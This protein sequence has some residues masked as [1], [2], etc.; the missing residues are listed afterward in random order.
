MIEN[1]LERARAVQE[2]TGPSLDALLTDAA[3]DKALADATRY[4]KGRYEVGLPH[5]TS[6]IQQIGISQGESV[7]DLGCGA[8]HWCIAA[9][10]AGAGQA[11]GVELRREFVTVARLMASAAALEDKA[12]FVVG[13]CCATGLPRE[14][15]TLAYSHSVMQYLN[16][17]LV[18]REA[19]RLLE[20]GG[21][22]YGGYTS[23][24]LRFDMTQ[25]SLAARDSKTA[26]ANL[27]TVLGT[28]LYDLAISNTKW[29]RMRCLERGKLSSLTGVYGFE[30]VATPGLQDG[31]KMFGAMECTID[32]IAS[33]ARNYEDQLAQTCAD[34]NGSRDR[35]IA[36]VR[37]LIRSGAAH[38][39]LDL[40]PRLGLETEV[41]LVAHAAVKAGRIKEFSAQCK[42]ANDPFVASLV[43]CEQ[44]HFAE[45]ASI[46]EPLAGENGDAGFVMA[47][48]LAAVGRY[49]EAEARFR[50]NWG[51]D[52][53]L[54]DL[55]GLL[56]SRLL[57]GGPEAAD[58][59]FA[60][61][62]PDLKRLGTA[63]LP[64]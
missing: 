42:V 48:C 8:G 18:V 60:V 30:I 28:G 57:D 55:S 19:S 20:V 4:A 31:A 47:Y 6:V 52:R 14:S 32:F 7:V 50:R 59:E 53:R 16:E 37:G 64:L 15:F 38:A 9:C 26:A 11:V 13:D 27:G 49:R 25:R 46:L 62:L 58:R 2:L 39:A 43:A 56:I 1:V 63:P 17:E 61:V 35:G 45:A 51:R 41:D 5:Y 44:W 24:G 29:S 3:E 12:R 40:I 34:A 10:L 36:A 23:V 33:K 22:F 21:R 54:R